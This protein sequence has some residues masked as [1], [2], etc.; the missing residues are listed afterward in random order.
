MTSPTLGQEL[1]DQRQALIEKIGSDRFTLRTSRDLPFAWACGYYMLGFFAVMFSV[2]LLPIR[3]G[4]L[5]L[6]FAAGVPLPFAAAIGWNIW[7][8]TRYQSIVF[9]SNGFQIC[10]GNLVTFELLWA[11]LR[12]VDSRRN[13]VIIT[14]SDGS[15]ESI[16]I[17]DVKRDRPSQ[18]F[19]QLV[20]TYAIQ[21]DNTAKKRKWFIA[22]V[23]MLVIGILGAT[24][25]GP[26]AMLN[27]TY[28]GPIGT[29]QYT[30][31]AI[32]GLSFSL[33]LASVQG[34]GFFAMTYL[35][36][37]E[38]AKGR[39]RKSR[40]G[41]NVQVH[42]D[43]SHNWPKPLSLELGKAYRYLD[44]DGVRLAIRESIMGMWAISGCLVLLAVFAVIAYFTAPNLKRDDVIAL[45]GIFVSCM[46]FAYLPTRF[47]P[48]FRKR[49]TWVDD[50]I[51]VEKDSLV[52]IR[53]SESYRYPRSPT[54]DMTDDPP[55]KE[56]RR[57]FARFERHGPKTDRYLIDRRFLLEV[58]ES[59]TI[60]NQ[61]NLLQGD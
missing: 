42:L 37:R 50:I 24:I 59:M 1:F 34:L 14:R 60:P 53:G 9:D 10:E 46:S 51:S 30:A 41:P 56:Q 54:K 40:F 4:D 58:G 49:M 3:S 25:G 31:V 26:P 48:G 5:R 17:P 12:S 28:D 47:V 61:V 13:M 27:K 11:C 55:K 8:K 18:L 45:I 43:Q 57:P 20:R 32:W 21:R 33:M 2:F 23:L 44:P 52:V 6:L 29:S 36:N 7:R 38:L 16:Q 39:Q 22:F 19:L 15:S 35:T